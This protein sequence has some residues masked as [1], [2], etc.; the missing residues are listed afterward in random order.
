MTLKGTWRA[1]LGSPVT[2]RADFGHDNSLALYLEN[3]EACKH[4][5]LLHV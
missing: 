1:F 4:E 2:F 5:T 3:K